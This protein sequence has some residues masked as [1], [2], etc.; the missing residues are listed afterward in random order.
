MSHEEPASTV[1]EARARIDAADREL[2][3][4]LA[5]RMKHVE[6]LSAIKRRE[7]LRIRDDTREGFVLRDRARW[8]EELALPAEMSES[9][10]RL[11]MRTSRDRQA[12][13]RTQAPAQMAKKT[14]AIIGACGGMGRR[15][16]GLFESLGHEVLQVDLDTELTAEA[17]ARRAD[18][19]VVSVP[20]NETE[21]VIQQVGPHVPAHGVLMDL[22]SIKQRPL[23][24]MLAS[25]NA[26][27]VGTH[28]MF[29]PGVRTLQ[30]Q[31]VVLC[32]GRGEAWL[33]WLE[34][35]LE[36]GGMSTTRASA[37][38]HDRAMAS[39]Q[40]LN[41]FQTQV[42]GLTLARLGAPLA[43]SLRFRSPAYLMELYVA[44]RHFGQ[45]PALYGPI[46][47]NNPQ[48]PDVTR[49]FAAAAQLIARMLSEH[50]QA[51]FSA[52]FAEVRQFF[53]DFTREATEQSAY[54]IDRIVERG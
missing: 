54:L 41:H 1:E 23:A 26:N 9:L 52:M 34:T 29:G 45:D 25:T 20:I 22:T 39:V 37:E 48:T 18:V 16:T 38:E 36:A 14:V 42:L 12:E 24:T 31:R 35:T 15:F 49:T 27:V 50:D 3:E 7:G 32:P 21:K 30:G 5:R 28:P 10:F 6:A 47:M 53:G 19:C 13:L 8:A 33:D 11:I 46:E 44:A 43:E 40:V 2:L 17:A 51:G 4:V